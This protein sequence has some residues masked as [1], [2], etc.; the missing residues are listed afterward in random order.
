[1]A[2]SNTVARYILR[3]KDADAA[4]AFY[5]ALLGHAGTSIVPLHEQALA[6]GAQPHWFGQIEVDDVEAKAVA[7]AELGAQRLGP[8]NAFPDGRKFAMLRDPTGALVGLTSEGPA[9]AAPLPV[10]WHQLDTNEPER[11]MQVYATLFGWRASERVTYGEHGAFQ[12]FSWGSGDGDAGF[13]SDIGGRPGRHPHWIFHVRVADLE[14][15]VALVRA[16]GGLVLG[17]FSLPS[18]ERLAVCDDPQGAG[19]ALR[20]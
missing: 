17:E 10:V 9:D 1:M 16:E 8:T 18:G 5:A 12:H 15:A 6:R 11:A 4:R 13:I 20:G 14:R 3:T 2:P 19:F 7:F